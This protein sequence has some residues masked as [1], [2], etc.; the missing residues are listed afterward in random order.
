MLKFLVGSHNYNLE[1]PS[2]DKDWKVFNY[3]TFEHLF[4][5]EY[6]N[7]PNFLS[8]DEDI[9]Y[10]DIRQLV[11]LLLKCNPAYLEVLYSKETE[12]SDEMEN[13]KFLKFIQDNRDAIAFHNLPRFFDACVGMYHQKRKL[14][15]NS[16]QKTEHYRDYGWDGEYGYSYKLAM[17]AYRSLD[18]IERLVLLIETICYE[19]A[20][21]SLKD[22]ENL[23]LRDNI[24]LSYILNGE[25][26]KQY[27]SIYFKVLRYSEFN[28]PK[29]DTF[30]LDPLFVDLKS[31]SSLSYQNLIMTFRYRE[32]GIKRIRDGQYTYKQ[33]TQLL[34]EKEEAIIDLKNHPTF[35]K[36][37]VNTEILEQAQKI[38]EKE[39]LERIIKTNIRIEKTTSVL[40]DEE[41][42]SKL[43]INPSIYEDNCLG[44]TYTPKINYI[45]IK[46][47]GKVNN[48]LHEK[49][50][51]P[52]SQF[53]TRKKSENE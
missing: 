4:K 32:I 15:E 19:E 51:L 31:N 10:K 2:S 52:S 3:P 12:H 13:S 43:P 20:S 22:P 5:G 39:I 23:L 8:E 48:D 36:K 28:D 50:N 18:L 44:I 27:Q 9:D 33:I 47:R 35:D 1:T 42:L 45:L 21:K 7:A 30:I 41:Y 53:K 16:T 11:P 26:Q 40:K 38:L 49:I 37:Y 24:F 14:L 25:Y 34:D 29:N 46:L 17:Q 6:N